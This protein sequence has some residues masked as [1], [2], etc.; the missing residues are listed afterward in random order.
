MKFLTIGSAVVDIIAYIEEDVAEKEFF[1]IRIGSKYNLNVFRF[2][3]GGSALNVAI[4]LSRLGNKTSILTKVG[5]DYYSRKIIEV[6]KKEKVGTKYIK[7]EKTLS[8]F[9]I[10]LM[11]KG[12]RSILVSHTVSKKFKE[13][14]IKKE[15]I[16]NFDVIIST[17]IF[18]LEAEKI[19]SKISEYCEKHEKFFVFNP[20]ITVLR[21]FDL[22][23]LKGN[24]IILNEEEAKSLTKENNLK[25]AAK[26][27]L[28][29]FEIVVITLGKKGSMLFTKKEQYYQEAYKVGI[30]STLGAGD[31]FTA[32]FTHYFFKYKNLQEALRFASALAAIN[33]SDSSPIPS[34]KSEQDVIDFIKIKS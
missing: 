22:S 15:I 4:T 8:D 27:M 20:S 16:K 23:F 5:N 26:K 17:S 1:K 13:K 32:G 10:V 29:N 30:V 11:H 28:E 6:L 25:K 2:D 18:S 33:I 31:S 9:S 24:I 3:I 34:I 12:E 14:D 7:R 21:K 19:Y